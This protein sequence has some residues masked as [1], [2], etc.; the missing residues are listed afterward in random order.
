MI[1]HHVLIIQIGGIEIAT[2]TIT[3]LLE[4]GTKSLSP[5]NMAF[6]EARELLA[7]VLQCELSSLNTWP[8]KE[9]SK[10]NV[11]TYQTLI[12]RR[13]KNEP[14][15]YIVGS[16][17]FGSLT[18]EVTSDTLIPRAQTELLVQTILNELDTTA[19]SVLDLGTGCG[20]IACCLAHLRPH[21][22][23]TATD[24]S[25]K[26]IVVAKRNANRLQLNNIQ[27]LESNWFN[28]LN[29]KTF[30]AIISN[31]PYIRDQDVPFIFG[32]TPEP[33]IALSAGPTGME[34]F[35]QILGE[36][37]TH[38]NPQGFIAFEHGFDQAENLTALFTQ[39]GF[40]KIQTIY[41]AAGNPRVTFGY[42]T[43]EKKR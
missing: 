42:A 37:K 41:D 28:A 3:E 1:I 15:S 34:A 17:S 32:D 25:A 5:N 40:E 38:L 36:C 20:T 26:A 13:K 7:Y 24:I 31:P 9:I 12:I 14:I 39:A 19:K 11:Q 27:F 4:W 16:K 29:N 30:D 8:G 18:F 2:N 33:K 43:R 21:W 10:E 6:F 22:V 35:I 23:L